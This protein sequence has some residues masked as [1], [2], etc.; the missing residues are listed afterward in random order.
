MFFFEEINGKKILKSDLI[1]NAKGFF[2]TR[3]ICICDKFDNK[4]DRSR[5]KYGMTNIVENNK[6]IISDYLKIDEKNLISPVQTHSANIEIA[7]IS[8]NDYPD[9]DALILTNKEQGI[10]LNFADCTPIIFYDEKQNIGA[11]AHAGWR[12]TAQKIA[13]LTAQKLINEFNTNKNDLKVLIGPA[14]CSDCYDVGENVY[15]EL[16]QTVSDFEG[17]YKIEKSEN[18]KILNQVQNDKFSYKNL[19]KNNKIYVDLK[20]INK[21]QLTDLGID[22]IDVCPYCTCCNNEYFYSYRKENGTTLR[23]SAVLKLL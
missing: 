4:T 2:T 16:K 13:I 15:N 12:G 14:I 8:K 10:F 17:L 18:L 22:N 5:I 20:N 7:Q 1:K 6:K 21:K 23:H 3:E 19:A 9:T 11:V